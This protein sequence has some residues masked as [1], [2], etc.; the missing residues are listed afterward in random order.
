MICK[1][2][3]CAGFSRGRLDTVVTLIIFWISVIYYF[4][5]DE[6][7]IQDI[8]FLYGC[9]NPTII[10]IY[11]DTH[12]RHIKTH[13]ISLKEKEFSKVRIFLRAN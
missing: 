9:S 6:L 2:Q 1:I 13:E 11:Q 8:E 3:G 7:Q 5:V 10:V 12:G 4:R